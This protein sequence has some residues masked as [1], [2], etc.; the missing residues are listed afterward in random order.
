MQP[1]LIRG[2]LYPP[3]ELPYKRGG[4][5][6]TVQDL[7]STQEEADTRIL[8]PLPNAA[9]SGYSTLIVVPCQKI[10]MSLNLCVIQALNSIVNFQVGTK[11]RVRYISITSILVAIR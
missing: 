7:H 4:Y 11:T 8:L 5:T 10:Q 3:G 2:C 1:V 6:S 9:R